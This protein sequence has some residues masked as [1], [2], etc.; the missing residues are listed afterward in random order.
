METRQRNILFAFITTA[1]IAGCNETP[2]SLPL[3]RSLES[4]GSATTAALG[5]RPSWM[6]RDAQQQSKLLY[7]SDAT[8]EGVAVYSYPNGKLEGMLTGIKDPRGSCTDAAGDIYVLNGSGMPPRISVYAHGATTPMRKLKGPVPL[9]NCTVDQTTGD[10]AVGVI[11]STVEIFSNGRGAPRYYFQRNMDAFGCAYDNAGNLF[12]S[13]F[14]A[15]RGFALYELPRGSDK[16][17]FKK[18]TVADTIGVKPGLMAWDGEELTVEN[19]AMV[20]QIV[21]R[22]SG[23]AIGMT[24][25]LT[26]LRGLWEYLIVPGR[27]IETSS[28]FGDTPQVSYFKY[29]AGG[30]ATKEIR[31]SFS[32][33]VGVSLSSVKN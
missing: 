17:Y 1:I 8:D 24:T 9:Q 12:C 4:A 30:T 28:G 5:V 33:P 14:S 6:L 32:E 3:P 27:L 13:G 25:T 15:N 7:V 29:P 11:G 26:G 2:P 20:Y 16:R 21:S 18:V 23:Y 19:G 22:P 31:T 10:L